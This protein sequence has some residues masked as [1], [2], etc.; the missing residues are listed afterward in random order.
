V[1][2][3]RDYNGHVCSNFPVLVVAGRHLTFMSAVSPW[4][5]PP[6]N[7]EVPSYVASTLTPYLQ[8]PHLLSLT[9][10]AY[11]ILSLA[12]IAFRLHLSLDSANDSIA[13]AKDGLLASC[14][15]AETAATSA[16]S[17]P[18]YLAIASNEQ[19]VHVVNGSLN[20]AR[21]TLVL[22][23]TAM[24]GIINFIVDIYR[25]TFLCFLELIVRGSLA[26]LLGAVNEVCFDLPFSRVVSV[27][28]FL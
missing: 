18:R 8:L 23:L 11:P 1:D 7:Y 26:L 24:E 22:A 14:K 12:F 16:A 25:S 6:P 27:D 2:V 10:I 3:L 9:W 4:T 19:F 20:A 21:E 15:A 28:R 5:S 17:M 13:S